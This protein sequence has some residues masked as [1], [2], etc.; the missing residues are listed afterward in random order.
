MTQVI[1]VVTGPKKAGKSYLVQ[2][3][4]HLFEQKREIGGGVAGLPLGYRLESI[5]GIP[6]TIIGNYSC[7]G[8]ARFGM[9]QFARYPR[10]FAIACAKISVMTGNILMED[11]SMNRFRSA[12][13]ETTF[14]GQ[15]R[16]H[17]ISEET[18]ESSFVS[19]KKLLGISHLHEHTKILSSWR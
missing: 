7:I 4:M 11:L 14:A 9:Y 1:T 5:T 6:L 10:D 2:R 13:F 19:L 15:I 17:A 18:R 3:I 8:R 12:E 16:Y